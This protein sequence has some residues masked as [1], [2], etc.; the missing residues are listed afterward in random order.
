[1]RLPFRARGGWA[2]DA[3]VGHLPYR[4]LVVWQRSIELADRIMEIAE[5]P[6]LYRRWSFQR[7]MCDAAG[8]IAANIAEGNGRSTPLDYAA[9]VDRARGSLFELDTWILL[10][11]RRGWI[12]SPT[13]AEIEREIEQISLMLLSLATR[14]RKS[15]QLPSR[16]NPYE[17][18]EE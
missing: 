8:S 11:H 9:F 14:L 18:R 4:K 1:V 16:A 7:Q 10:A 6:A 17:F 2:Y 15:A 13:Q 5:G 12:D 3:A